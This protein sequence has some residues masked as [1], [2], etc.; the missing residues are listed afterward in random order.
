MGLRMLL[1]LL[2]LLLMLLLLVPLGR[3]HR[4]E[5]SE[6]ARFQRVALAQ[7]I[8]VGVLDAHVGVVH[9]L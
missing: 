2:L 9:V 1:L 4:I 3:L 6:C 7:I 8:A 5:A